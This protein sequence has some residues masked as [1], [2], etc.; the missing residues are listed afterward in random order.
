MGKREGN[1]PQQF[2]TRIALFTSCAIM[3]LSSA[4]LRAQEAITIDTTTW[5]DCLGQ[6]TCQIGGA[7]LTSSAGALIE[8][9]T[10]GAVGI[11]ID[12]GPSGPEIDLGE[13][14]RITF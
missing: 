13:T 7:T 6:T 4:A 1:M 10:N 5:G 11:G 2:R 3:A 14:L 9:E 12:G 8:K